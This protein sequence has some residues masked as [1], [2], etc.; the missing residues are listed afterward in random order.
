MNDVANGVE[1]ATTKQLQLPRGGDCG[2][3][4]DTSAATLT[5]LGTNP[6]PDRKGVSTT[7]DPNGNE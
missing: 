2:N 3:Q 5:D 1:T 6:P 7:S 4:R